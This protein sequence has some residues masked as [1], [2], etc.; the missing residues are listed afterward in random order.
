MVPLSPLLLEELRA[1][2]KHYRPTDWLFPG[3][4]PGQ[5]RHPG[6]LQRAMQRA[7]RQCGLKKRATPHTLRHSFATHLLEA[8]TD[9]A[10]LQMLL[11]HRQL[12]TTLRYAHVA[13]KAQRTLS[14]LDSLPELAAESALPVGMEVQVAPPSVNPATDATAGRSDG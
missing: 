2:W 8:G 13:G 11:G 3:T 7:C 5:P 4:K 10:T 14:P 12:S 1:Y 9:L 6:T